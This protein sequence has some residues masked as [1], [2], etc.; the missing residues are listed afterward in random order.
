MS[1]ETEQGTSN[2]QKKEL[3]QIIKDKRISL[4]MT[5]EELADKMY[6][7]VATLKRH[8]NGITEIPAP[9]LFRYMQALGLTFEEVAPDFLKQNTSSE[10]ELPQRS[11]SSHNE[12]LKHRVQTITENLGDEMLE[13]YV[14]IGE[15]LCM[16]QR[17]I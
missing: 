15:G 3:C 16:S 6:I 2:G 1:A 10:P 14:A 5:R 13:H 12:D 11:G 4:G 8:E 7:S 9:F 17:N